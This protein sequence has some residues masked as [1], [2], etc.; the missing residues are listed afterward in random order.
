M[1]PWRVLRRP[2]ALAL[3]AAVTAVAPLDPQPAQAAGGSVVLTLRSA[4]PQALA[5]AALRAPDGPGEREARA[6][7]LT[8][9][10]QARRSVEQWLLSNGF[11][12]EGSTSWTVTAR[13]P[14]HRVTGRRLP[15]ELRRSVLSAV[16]EAAS[17]MRPRAVPVGWSP[18]ALRAAYGVGGPTADGRGTSV[19]TIQFSG[20]QPTDA[21]VFARA[22]GIALEPGQITTHTVAG[23][24]AHVPDGGG[25]DFEVAL[26]VETALGAAP[27]ARQH[28]YVAP[29]TTSGALAV[30]DAVAT[31]AERSGLTAVS[32]SW[33]ACEQ[34]SAPQLVQ[35]LEQSL[36]RMVAAGTTVFAASGDAGA[37]GCATPEDPDGRLAVDYP[38]ASPSVLAVGGTTLRRQ[39]GGWTETAWS[40]RSS[41][42]TGYAGSGTGGGLSTLFPQ[43]VWQQGLTDEPRRAVPDLAA[44]A[45]PRTGIGIYG[46]DGDG[47]HGWLTGGGTSGSAPLLAGQLASTVSGLG[48][49]LGFGRLHVPLY[50]AGRAGVGVRDVVAGDN[51]RHPAGPGYDLA[52]GL[53][54]PQWAALGPRLLQPALA[55]PAATG[56]LQVAVAPYAPVSRTA[57]Y[58][59]AETAEAACAQSLTAPPATLALPE[60]PDRATAAVLA[61][62]DEDRCRT[63]ALPLVLDRT[64]PAARAALGRTSRPHVLA[65]S[66]GGSDPAPSSGLRAVTW[67]LRRTDTGA[68]V[69]SA[70]AARS[71]TALR[72]VPAGAS[73]VLEVQARDSLGNTSGTSTSSVVAVG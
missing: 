60:G 35:A 25:G 37:Y 64:A 30:Y 55:G 50:A 24:Q 6:Q 28:V 16:R 4:A 66:W 21:Q 34:R 22:A 51:L 67:R 48:R 44:V 36:A 58:G 33:G 57:R 73:Y 32:I 56:D 8:P 15:P 29:N 17:P 1:F 13:G 68:V 3:L 12:L 5:S 49:T 47:R 61:V 54:T 18:E 42:A 14:A 7:Q 11:T 46:P 26:D 65:L 23:A 31:H 39:A 72:P 71:G 63:T 27:A 62:L 20:W 38:A 52:T 40:D 2:L 45:D 19:A 9:S 10:A 69:A 59:L 53:G 43:P 41:A 70:N